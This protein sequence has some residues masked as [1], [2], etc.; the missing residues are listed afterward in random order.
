LLYVVRTESELSELEKPGKFY[1]AGHKA[2]I[3]RVW[4][5]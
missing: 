1:S 4:L 3:K 2:Y 5:W